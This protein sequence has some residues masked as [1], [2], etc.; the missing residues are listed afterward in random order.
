MGVVVDPFGH[1]VSERVVNAFLDVGHD[2]R[3]SL[4]G[5]EA[6]ELNDA[7]PMSLAE[8]LPRA[9]SRATRVAPDTSRAIHCLRSGSRAIRASHCGPRLATATSSSRATFTPQEATSRSESESHRFAR[10]MGCFP[11]TRASPRARWAAVMSPWRL[12]RTLNHA[13]GQEPA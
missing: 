11:S 3:A 5:K 8:L 13:K 2:G 10:P 1:S 9:T 12:T 6:R 4:R 7:T